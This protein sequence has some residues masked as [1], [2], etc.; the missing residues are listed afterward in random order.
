MA[1]HDYVNNRAAAKKKTR[2]RKTMTYSPQARSRGSA[3][4]LLLVLAV[5]LLGALMS[6]RAGA[7]TLFFFDEEADG[8]GGT[9]GFYTFDTE[10]GAVSL[11]AVVT[12]GSRFFSLARRPS[13]GAVFGLDVFPSTASASIYTVDFD[14]GVIQFVVQAT[15]P[16][17][18][19]G[20]AD[21]T[22]DPLTGDLLAIDRAFSL[23]YSVDLTTGVLTTIGDAGAGFL[24]PP[25]A[26][27]TFAPDGSL[28][29]FSAD[30][31]GD[32]GTLFS[33]NPANANATLVGNGGPVPL[34]L[35]DGTFARDGIFYVS[36]FD[37][38]IHRVDTSTGVRT[39]IGNT[40]LGPGLSGLIAA[41][42]VQ[43]IAIDIKPGSD[44]NCFNINGHGVI[45]VAIL[46]S[47]DF[48]V[49][50]VDHSNLSFGGLE[51]RVRGQKGAMCNLDYSNKDAHLDLVC[52]F[53][54]DAN[55]WSPGNDAATLTG[56]LLDGGEF[57]G[58]DSICIVP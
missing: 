48:D 51:V 36:D 54:D 52:Y 58:T 3:K 44:P 10:T 11:V 29:A 15:L 20:I 45:P 37:G 22:F 28:F 24:R 50:D 6:S 23:L 55:A 31:Q 33:I 4:Q 27:L 9:T 49:N 18:G 8:E 38:R 14:T 21:I 19:N 47:E 53:E 41:E 43:S 7:T 46:G 32:N 56:T 1:A 30:V 34:T 25:R 40:A 42:F 2:G 13:D 57:E 26:A 16:P 39:T 35:E 5:V 17:E 12:G